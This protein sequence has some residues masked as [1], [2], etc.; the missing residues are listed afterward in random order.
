MISARFDRLPCFLQEF[1]ARN[2]LYLPLHTKSRVQ[3]QWIELKFPDPDMPPM[4][5]YLMCPAGLLAHLAIYTY[6]YTYT[7]IYIHIYIYVCMYIYIHMYIYIY[8]CVYIYICIHTYVYIYVHICTTVCM[9]NHAK[10][11]DNFTVCY[12]KLHIYG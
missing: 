10:G 7:H 9:L 4:S 1:L 11:R 6:I 3:Y 2:N 12:R 5:R 8:I